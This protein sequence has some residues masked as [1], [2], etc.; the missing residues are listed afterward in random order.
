ME[1]KTNIAGYIRVS[2]DDQSNSIET[3]E[4]KIREYCKF[5]NFNPAHIIIDED[6]SGGTEFNKRPGGKILQKLLTDNSITTIIAIK[7]DRLFRNVT[8]ALLTTDQW[9][10]SNIDL[11]IIDMGGASFSTKSAIGRL[12]FTTIISFA[13]F[14]RNITGE[15]TKAVI[16]HKKINM[17][18]YSKKIFG[19]DSIENKLTPNPQEQITLKKIFS[20]HSQNLSTQ[21]IA[22]HL[23]SISS[24]PTKGGKWIRSSILYII[25]NDF[26]K[27]NNIS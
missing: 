23:N 17:I 26:Y 16:N 6:I 14:E 9:N 11:H 2:T 13:E 15:R 18:R 21:K 22:D 19:Y 12:M 5:K 24:K 8:D 7:P 27:Q 25:K 4:A 1:N 20:M 10:K 3:Q